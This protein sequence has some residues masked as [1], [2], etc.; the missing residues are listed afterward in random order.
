V[1][2]VDAKESRRIL[3]DALHTNT[4][5][6]PGVSTKIFFIGLASGFAGSGVVR[7]RGG[8]GSDLSLWRRG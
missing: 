2:N 1:G 4:S 5:I 8:R 7:F 6:C 3:P